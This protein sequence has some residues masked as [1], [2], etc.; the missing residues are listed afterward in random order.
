MTKEAQALS[1]VLSPFGKRESYE[2]SGLAP[3]RASLVGARL[4]LLHN[5]KPNADAL[6]SELGQRLVE[7]Y[8]VAE[9]RTFEKPHFGVPVGEP[10]LSAMLESCD[11]ALAG[12]GD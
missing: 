10:Q 7:R 8:G 2:A 3:R 12:V 11:V 6:L 1:A 9:V 4:G 5:G